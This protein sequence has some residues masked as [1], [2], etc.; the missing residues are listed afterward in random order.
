M[1]DVPVGNTVITDEPV[2]GPERKLSLT[3]TWPT[4]PGPRPYGGTGVLVA[5]N[6]FVANGVFDAVD[7]R[8]GVDVTVGVSVIVGV[9]LGV[10]VFTAVADGVTVPIATT[11]SDATQPSP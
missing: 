4:V 1:I 6:V 11:Q 3:V 8:D 10:D 5:V 2:E 9:L 7:V